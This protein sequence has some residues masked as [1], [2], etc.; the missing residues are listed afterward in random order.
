MM[1]KKYLK[2]Y[3]KN[4]LCRL[5]RSKRL[6]KVIDLG[7]T[8][9]ANSFSY[10]KNKKQFLVPLG[11]D[12]CKKCYHLQL[13]HIADAKK[14][15]NNYLYVSGTSKVTIDHFKLYS[16]ELKKIFLKKNKVKVLDIASNDGTFLKNFKSKKF[17][18]YGIDPA[19]NLNKTISDNKLK[20]MTGFF[21]KKK[22]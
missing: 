17:D 7:K 19:R 11:V 4:Y 15:F 12:F 6:K 20:I 8:P 3:K 9:L 21:S 5:C 13:T 10:S 16:E 18:V 1:Q 22:K 14:M 2:Y